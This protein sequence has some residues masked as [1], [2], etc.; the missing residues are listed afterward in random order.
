MKDKLPRINAAD[1]IRV[2]EKT[3]FLLLARQSG[4]HKIYKNAEGRRITAPFHSRKERFFAVS[5]R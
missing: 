4:S 2:L 3:G 5:S 1:A